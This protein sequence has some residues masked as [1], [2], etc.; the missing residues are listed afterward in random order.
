MNNEVNQY[1]DQEVNNKRKRKRDV[2]C[3]LDD[4]C[5]DGCCCHC[6]CDVCSCMECDCCGC[7]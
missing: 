2:D 6:D 4:C 5:D 7:M 3:C 1:Q